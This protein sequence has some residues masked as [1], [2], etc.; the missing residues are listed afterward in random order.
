MRREGNFA[1]VVVDDIV[2]VASA[3]HQD[4]VDVNLFG[5]S[6]HHHIRLVVGTSK[7]VRTLVALHAR[8]LH[9][10]ILALGNRRT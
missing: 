5:S 10:V 7:S 2:A 1:E 3:R 4:S 8:N 9:L 6:E